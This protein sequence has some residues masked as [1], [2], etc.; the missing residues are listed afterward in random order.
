MSDVP[1][2]GMVLLESQDVASSSVVVVKQHQRTAAEPDESAS[3]GSHSATDVETNLARQGSNFGLPIALNL[4]ILMGGAIG[5][6]EVSPSRL[7]QVWDGDVDVDV[8]SKSRVF[9]YMM[10]VE[11]A[12]TLALHES[13]S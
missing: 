11:V 13:S 2:V 4:T 3:K 1:A 12:A 5:I 9:Y 7:R 8:D 10:L 6:T